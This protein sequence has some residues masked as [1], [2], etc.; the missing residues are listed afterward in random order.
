[1]R[2]GRGEEIS[3]GRTKRTLLAD[4]LEALIAAVYLDGG[5]DQ[6]RMFV[7]RHV[8]AVPEDCV[9]QTLLDFK[10][11]LQELTQAQRLPHPRYAI[12]KE[13]GPDHSKTFTIEARVGRELVSQG[14]GH[15][16]KS[17]A[18][19]AAREI[20]ERLVSSTP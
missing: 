9:P 19:K 2:L 11:A 5:L 3:G 18:Q 14:E 1:L 6:A 12:V 20:Y 16:K 8:M 4:A 17:A 7:T 15:T 10:S 13:Q